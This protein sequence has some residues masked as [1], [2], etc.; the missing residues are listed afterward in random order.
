[1]N[2]I[3]GLT[4]RH[5]NELSLLMRFIDSA[6]IA[7]SLSGIF[8]LYNVGKERVDEYAV[9]GLVCILLFQF[10][11]EFTHLYRSYRGEPVSR[12]FN[13]I[14][15]TWALAFAVPLVF[16]F[17]SKQTEFYSRIVLSSWV[18]LAP[19]L[20]C[21][22]RSITRCA[23][24][25]LRGMGI[26]YRNACICGNSEQAHRLARII[27]ETPDMGL[28][29]NG[30]YADSPMEAPDD[31]A[32]AGSV[33]DMI[34]L[35][36]AGELDVVYLAFGVHEMERIN[37]IIHALA[38]ST[39][40]LYVV[41]GFETYHLFQSPV[42]IIGGIPAL[43]VYDKPLQGVDGLVKRI[44]DVI[45]GGLMLMIAAVPML[46]ISVLV[47]LTSH[48]PILFKQHRY[49]MDGRE[50]VIW[51]FR[52]MCVCED[53][54]GVQQAQKGDQRVTKLGA[55]LRRTS[56]DELPQ[57]LN[58]LHGSMS[59]VGP[60]PHAVAHNEEYRKQIHGYMLRHKVKP[61][62]TGLAQIRG[63]RGETNTLE[64][65]EK[66]VECDLEY[67]RTW[68]LVL[69]IKILLVTLFRGFIHENAY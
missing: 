46:M 4:H 22:Q 59:L 69:D 42:S 19:L 5:S 56:L 34:A 45:M 36:Q 48:G 58:V 63:W 67:I 11:A 64:K 1:M 7:L 14:W 66:R 55:F 62:I 57:L 24:R 40:D 21:L 32:Y 9:L 44:E 39:V 33:E 18:M 10:L 8:A 28:Q 31:V 16:G 37:Q 6:I 43:S 15:R 50:I 13:Y 41:P 17:L 3:K 54:D 61:G 2:N 49:G 20:I 68:S 23:L 60:R 12:E 35:A 30:I 65:M 47:K 29:L 26:N 38:D 51:K 52:T 25:G 27:R 53:G